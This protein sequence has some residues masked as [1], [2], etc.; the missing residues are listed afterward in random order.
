MRHFAK[1]FLALF[2]LI[3]ALT[4]V[5]PASAATLGLTRPF[6]GRVISSTMP[7]VTCPGT[8]PV[9]I[10]PAGTSL[11]SPYF[12]PVGLKTPPTAGRWVLGNHLLTPTPVCVTNTVPPVPYP[13]FMVTLYGISRGF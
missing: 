13:A 1:A 10:Q 6:G 5:S 11:S 2:I 9:T 8:G 12:F 4:V 7:G 3:T